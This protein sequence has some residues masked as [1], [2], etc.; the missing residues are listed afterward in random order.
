MDIIFQGNHSSDEA[1]E[2]LIN[3]IRM[4]KERY[5]IQQF[6]EMHLTVTLVDDSGEDVEL[7]DSETAEPYRTFEVYREGCEL[8]RRRGIPMLKLV[9]DN[10]R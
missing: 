7:V 10:T 5:Q 1:T 4:F 8:T 6:R 2:S 3:V 9:I